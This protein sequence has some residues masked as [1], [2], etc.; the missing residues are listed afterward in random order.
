MHAKRDE[1]IWINI[2]WDMLMTWCDDKMRLEWSLLVKIKNCIYSD[3]S[4]VE[5]NLAGKSP[6]TKKAHAVPAP[7]LRRS[8]A[9]L[10][11]VALC[12]S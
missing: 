11:F 8:A 4:F 2:N 12:I 10:V 5:V 7:C 1:N 9:V 6:I 3:G